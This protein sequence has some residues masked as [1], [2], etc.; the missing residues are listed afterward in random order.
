M[1]K[2]TERNLSSYFYLSNLF[3]RRKKAGI[4]WLIFRIFFLAI[5]F[6]PN[7]AS[8]THINGADISYKWIS[9]NTFELSLTLYR[10]C[11]GIA[12]PLSVS[13]NCKSVSCGYNLNATLNRISGTGQEI[14]FTCDS[15]AST[16]AGGTNPGIQKY[17]YSG[18]ITLPVQCIDWI[19]GYNICCRNCAI[20][21][22]SYSPNNCTGVPS[23]YVEA[24][25]NNL[26][27][28]NNSSPVFTNVPVSF[29][30]IG[31][32]FHYNH[33]AYDANGD[34]LV[35]SLIDPK[36]S[37]I[38]SVVFNSGFSATNPISSSPPMSLS[39]NGDLIINPT[40][41]EVGVMAL[42][43]KE[44]RNG[45]L[46]G[47]VMRDMELWTRS[48]S[49]TLPGLSGINGSSNFNIDAC[50]GR[51]INFYVNSFDPNAGQILTL[52]FNNTIPGSVFTTNT[53][54]RPTGAFSWTPSASDVRALPYTIT[55]TI[56]DNN[57]PTN[58]FQTYSYNITVT[59]RSAFI[60][61]TNS[62]CASPG[63]GTANAFSQ[64]PGPLQ[65]L[66]SPGGSV[67]PAISG[68]TAGTYSVV[69]TDYTG[70]TASASTSISSPPIMNLS[71]SAT[72][73][74]CNGSSNGS[75]AVVTSGG[76][77]PYSYQWSPL[78]STNA[79]V[80]GLSAGTYSVVVQDANGC[81]RAATTTLTQP[82]LLTATSA[83]SALLCNDDANGT[84]TVSPSGGTGSYSYYWWNGNTTSSV[85]GLRAGNYSVVII[86]S[87]GCTIS[88]TVAVTQPSAMVINT[89]FTP[90]DCGF[91]N[92]T[93]TVI[94]S[95]GTG[96]YQYSWNPG[97]AT[98]AFVSGLVAGVYNVN[99][100]DANGCT[101]SKTVS[102]TNLN[103]QM[104]MTANITTSP[105]TCY[106]GSDGVATV[107]MSGGTGPYLYK[108]SSGD[109]TATASGLPSGN[110]SLKVTDAIGCVSVFYTV[111]NSAS[112][113]SLN[114]H[115]R[116]VKCNNG[117]DG[118]A[119]VTTSGG[120]PG[121]TYQWSNGESSSSVADFTA[122]NYFLT[123]IDASGCTADT[124]VS[125]SQPSQI[126]L[127]TSKIDIT[128]SG[129]H[130]GVAS[131]HAS[132]GLPP[133]VYEWGPVGGHDS[134]AINLSDGQYMVRVKDGNGCIEKALTE[135]L[136]S[137]SI[138]VST[139]ITE[140]KCFGE[141]N[142]SAIANVLGGTTPYSYL[143]SNGSTDSVATNLSSGTYNVSVI[144]N[145]GCTKIQTVT[146][147]QPQQ[148]GVSINS[149]SFVC[150]GQQAILSATVP[151]GNG[152]YSFL[153][154]NGEQSSSISVS[155]Q[156]TNSYSVIVTD[157]KGCSTTSA[158]STIGIYPPLE[159]TITS[160]DTVCEGAA[161][162]LNAS[163][164]GGN[165]GPYSYFW[166][167]GVQGKT[168]TAT[169]QLN[170]SFSVTVSDGC[171]TPNAVKS[172]TLFIQSNPVVNYLPD[173]SDGCQPLTVKFINQT[174]DG[175]KYYWNFGDG[176][177][178]S[179]RNPVHTFINAGTYTVNH[180]VTSKVGCVGKIVKPASIVVYPLP[181]AGFS[182]VPEE[183]SIF[184]PI[185]SFY[186]ES[187]NA[188][189][190]KWDFEDGSEIIHT[191]NSQHVF[192]DTGYYSVKLI[193]TS[194][195]GCVDTAY[196]LVL[197]KGEY[198]FY[199]PN[200]FTP[201]NDGVN[202]YFT[203][204]GVGV[205]EFEMTIY[206]RWGKLVYQ[207]ND[208]NRGWSGR[209]SD[210]EAFCQADVYVYRISIVDVMGRP[211]DYVGH[212]NLVR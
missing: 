28:P 12:A 49:N 109:S 55:L 169:A 149:P 192:T 96:P 87:R 42:L 89:S 162:V 145:R 120:R 177:S 164:T 21:T 152:N 82:T 71:L 61:S 94:A 86:D 19:F 37:S 116:P 140:V 184:N 17:Q 113:L 30:C 167:G 108:W 1:K 121:Y 195:R 22:L 134:V 187:M 125:I 174:N 191:K 78:F 158:L 186:D 6:I 197:I 9:G 103:G 118:F 136:S 31:Q 208:L 18:N 129:R 176:T 209:E 200:A 79:N 43:V 36:S 8:A 45:I 65:Y 83:G 54:S 131:V 138:S 203:A 194:E 190:W 173:N 24:T 171:T 172:K 81:T 56:K 198:A 135:I 72:N 156:S 159:A 46:I 88:K 39:Q 14:T 206:N 178:D 161:V 204:L 91:I 160:R 53:A 34:S 193:A 97:G 23:T 52:L 57:C 111:I 15:A 44:Y 68:L 133:Y 35:Y 117:N 70:C 185:I 85:S 3:K 27:F 10:D 51:P 179:S 180:L 16:C 115:S 33:G 146:I 60:Q 157:A 183:A 182:N 63:N 196:K 201:N 154:N 210:K 122:G 112:K 212:V 151:G 67:S 188:I 84:V 74:S 38:N 153:W 11:S 128:C 144:D 4:H 211:H 107:L 32:T 64:G 99:V 101:K 110:H 207:S 181:H 147:S 80:S 127:Q 126:V 13:A 139:A 137:S 175:E 50:P 165:G 76:V 66:W 102:V 93:A 59:N 123:V 104:P 40:S 90:V 205:K 105:V 98:T 7:N 155:P 95:G 170:A 58:G 20:T 69:V 189:D 166:N 119:S 148:I 132:G 142:G 47:S 29:F 25:L 77:S 130:D 114:I 199:I 73:P 106:G 92:G 62:A 202:D 168:I 75:L 26:S 2:I 150:I 5:Y 100:T 48:C 141:N 41:L 124:V 163:G 143:W